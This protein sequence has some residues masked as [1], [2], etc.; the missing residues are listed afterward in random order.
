MP[1]VFCLLFSACLLAPDKPCGSTSLTNQVLNTLAFSILHLTSL[2]VPPMVFTVFC[3]YTKAFNTNSRLVITFFIGLLLLLIFID[4]SLFGFWLQNYD[5]YYDCHLTARLWQLQ[6]QT[7]LIWKQ[8]RIH[9]HLEQGENITA[10]LPQLL[11]LS[12]WVSVM[13]GVG[14]CFLLFFC[15]A[16]IACY[17]SIVVCIHNIAVSFNDWNNTV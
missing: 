4:F 16:E 7:L 9:S 17:M 3:K 13:W 1:T 12:I 11:N 15:I 6:V 14:D 8:T 2:C 5:S 10:K